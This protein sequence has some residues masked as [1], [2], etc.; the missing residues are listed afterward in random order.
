MSGYCGFIYEARFMPDT[1]LLDSEIA[2]L[3][4]IPVE[5]VKIAG[6]TALAKIKLDPE[7]IEIRE[8]SEGASV[9]EERLN[10]DDEFIYHD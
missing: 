4:D 5:Q 10:H 3:L 1:P 6:E 9:V 8:A 7:I 2:A